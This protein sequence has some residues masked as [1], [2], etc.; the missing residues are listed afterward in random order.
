[1]DLVQYKNNNSLPKSMVLILRY[2]ND[3]V[4]LNVMN[5]TATYF[6]L[7]CADNHN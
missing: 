1:M 3:N 6:Y 5:K 7:L 4:I 2:I